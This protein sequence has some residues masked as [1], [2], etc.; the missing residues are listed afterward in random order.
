MISNG[1][2]KISLE[3]FLQVRG[4]STNNFHLN[5]KSI[6]LKKIINMKRYQKNNHYPKYLLNEIYMNQNTKRKT[7]NDRLIKKDNSL[8]NFNINN[9]QRKNTIYN[10]YISNF[11]NV[12]KPINL[13]KREKNQNENL[14]I[15]Y[16]YFNDT[17]R[18]GNKK[19][20]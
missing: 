19:I 15:N 13:K 5:E 8:N 3:E 16:N 2:S 17:L 7:L 4:I 10:N 18:T 9:N 14:S 11:G 6:L 12:I 20:N 1:K